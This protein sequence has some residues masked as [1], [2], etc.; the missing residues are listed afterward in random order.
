MSR[1]EFCRKAGCSEGTL[2][3][4]F[5]SWGNLRVR[6]GLSR[7]ERRGGARVFDTETLIRDLKAAAEEHGPNLSIHTFARHSGHS[8]STV[9]TRFGSWSA[10]REAAGLPPVAARR[11]YTSERL[12]ELG[13]KAYADLGCNLTCADFI[14]SSRIAIGTIRRH[15]GS[16]AEFRRQIG[17]HPRNPGNPKNRKYSRE[18]IIEA[19]RRVAARTGAGLSMSEFCRQ[20][21]FSENL[22]YRHFESWAEARDCADLPPRVPQRAK[23]SDRF[24]LEDLHAVARTCGRI[25]T[26]A[27]YRASGRAGVVTLLRRFGPT[28]Q[29][30]LRRYAGYREFLA[31]FPDGGPQPLLPGQSPPLP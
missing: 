2:V 1:G 26:E 5:G 24:L 25:P 10:F 28:W 11:G 19:I 22:L 21:G 7:W 16:W 6:L 23:L 27:E 31:V 12:L 14:R 3:S 13:R 4:Q 8:N 30:V 18:G 29:D 20:T 15:F 17:P 9:Y